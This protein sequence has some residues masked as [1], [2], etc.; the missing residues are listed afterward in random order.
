M[1]TAYVNLMLHDDTELFSST[2]YLKL[3]KFYSDAAISNSKD[4]QHNN[5]FKNIIKNNEKKNDTSYAT[6]KTK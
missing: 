2:E 4:N 3:I 1:D 5:F 6:T